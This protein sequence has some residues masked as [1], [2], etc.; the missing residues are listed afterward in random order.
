M[1]PLQR[2]KADASRMDK[3][4]LVTSRMMT[5]RASGLGRQEHLDWE[6]EEA[7]DMRQGICGRGG[8]DQYY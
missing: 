6:D 8:E 2:N 4:M 7:G 1:M 3:A 5:R